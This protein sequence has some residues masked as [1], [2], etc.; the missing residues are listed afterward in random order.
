MKAATGKG[1]GQFLYRC[2]CKGWQAR[3]DRPQ[4][5][6]Q[7]GDQEE[8]QEQ[9]CFP[10]SFTAYLPRADREAVAFLLTV[11][12][13]K[14]LAASTPSSR[15]PSLTWSSHRKSSP[16]MLCLPWRPLL[17]TPSQPPLSCKPPGISLW[18]LCPACPS[19]SRKSSLGV[20]CW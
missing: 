19:L 20:S 3:S 2:H 18:P 14:K 10:T 13:S 1:K 11:S 7:E 16:I 9:E 15:R 17:A 8:F 12:P 6:S 5:R 4:K